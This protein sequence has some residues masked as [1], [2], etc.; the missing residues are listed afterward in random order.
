MCVATLAL[1]KNCRGF[2]ESLSRNL[3]SVSI[4]VPNVILRRYF[5]AERKPGFSP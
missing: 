4:A 2:G 3:R 5:A 1:L